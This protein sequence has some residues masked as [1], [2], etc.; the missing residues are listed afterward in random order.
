MVE[1][2]PSQI[3]VGV[4]ESFFSDRKICLKTRVGRKRLID[5]NKY[6]DAVKNTVS[7]SDMVIG[8]FLSLNRST[9]YR[10][11]VDER[12]KEVIEDAK[13][14]LNEI[15]SINFNDEHISRELFKL[16]PTIKRWINIQKRRQ[17][18]KRTMSNRINVLY[19]V[20]TCLKTHPDNLRLDRVAELVVN[21]R[22]RRINGENVPKGLSYYNI[23]K[24]IRSFF[25]L[26]RGISGERLSD[27][28]IEAN[29]SE[30]SGMQAK[31]K[32]TPVQ[33][34]KFEDSVKE[35]LIEINMNKVNYLRKKTYIRF[36]EDVSIEH[37]YHELMAINYFMY[38]TATRINATLGI[39]LND[40]KHKFSD[41]KW[42]IHVLDKGE[43]GGQHWQKMLVDDGLERMKNYLSMRFG[44]SKEKL[45]MELSLID[46]Y[47]FP[48]WYNKYYD[49]NSIN[50]EAF[51]RIGV[52]TSI[53]N[54]IFRH[55]FAQ[56]GLHATGFNYELV[57]SLG[58]W[59]S[60]TT[61][62]VFYGE[63]SDDVKERGL[64]KMMGLPV[65]EINYEL[66]W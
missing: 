15:E 51:K 53:P 65:K 49:I 2:V 50:K 56:D 38:Y 66:R 52:I 24:P 46:D 16:I 39:M 36:P 31:E 60:T 21:M 59:S 63:M 29:R 18:N 6:L 62:K 58:G 41:S 37:I 4:T 10:F 22:D 7:L 54:H 45:S 61:M 9:V 13:R 5:E 3:V 27:L 8:S 11:R 25:E 17:L 1:K 64:R 42:E 44:I 48:F 47:L 33:R 19:N 20:C 40:G 30:G 34:M 55:T 35:I 26:I 32:I 12:N 14:Y 23:R 43:K 28:G 57:A